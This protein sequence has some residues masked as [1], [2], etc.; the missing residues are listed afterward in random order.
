MLY[1][2][3]IGRIGK[4]ATIISGAHGEFL[5]LDAAVSDYCKGQETTIW[6]RVKSN[7]NVH[8]AKW[9][10]KGRLILV[11]GTMP[12]PTIW[13]DKEGHQHIQVSVT[14]D[15]IHFVNSGRKKEQTVNAGEMPEE[16][17]ET[18]KPKV[19]DPL[20]APD[21]DDDLPF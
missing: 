15:N 12:A 11:E 2:H 1:T 10:T 5:S 14:A 20:P 19:D 13:T 9:L 16:T 4:D 17:T 7:R 18:G 3:F 6:V 21:G 8:L